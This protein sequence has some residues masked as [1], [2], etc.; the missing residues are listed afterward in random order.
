MPGT[1][2]TAD[3]EVM[4]R[5][6]EG[7][8]RDMVRRQRETAM[9]VWHTPSMPTACSRLSMSRIRFAWGAAALSSSTCHAM[10]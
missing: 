10:W 3:A 1:K 8:H 4:G 5:D 2:R 9:S 6:N 7:L